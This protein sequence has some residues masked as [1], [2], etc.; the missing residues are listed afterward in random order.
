[1]H[2]LLL[3]FLFFLL[4]EV[5]IVDPLYKHAWQK[6]PVSMY[7]YM[8]EWL[9]VEVCHRLRAS[10]SVVLVRCCISRILERV[11]LKHTASIMCAVGLVENL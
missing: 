5:V 4:T 8:H 3:S 9:Q 7:V 6:A 2:A 10:D 11:C 1:M